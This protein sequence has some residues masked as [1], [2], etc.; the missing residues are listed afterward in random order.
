MRR[1]QP[2]D[3]IEIYGEKG[4]NPSPLG[5]PLLRA[6]CSQDHR[7]E[8]AAFGGAKVTATT[9]VTSERQVGT[10]SEELAMFT[11]CALT[12]CREADVRSWLVHNMSDQD[13]PKLR[14]CHPHMCTQSGAWI[15]ATPDV[16]ASTEVWRR[17]SGMRSELR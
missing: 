13:A 5:I 14:R 1:T 12:D 2:I 16:S 15:E 6:V 17:V 7:T 8:I 9:L 3:F 10:C 11:P 4:R